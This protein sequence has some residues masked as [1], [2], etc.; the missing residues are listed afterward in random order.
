MAFYRIKEEIQLPLVIT[1]RDYNMDKELYTGIVTL[2]K[3][4]ISPIIDTTNSS[5]NIPSM[6]IFNDPKCKIISALGLCGVDAYFVLS[7]I[8]DGVYTIDEVFVCNHPHGLQGLINE[9]DGK[10]TIFNLNN[11]ARR[12]E[13]RYVPVGVANRLAISL[14]RTPRD[15]DVQHIIDRLTEPDG[16]YNN[17]DVYILTP[18]EVEP[19]F[20]RAVDIDY[21][22]IIVVDGGIGRVRVV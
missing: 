6:F 12:L 16:S 19:I 20:G 2:L 17:Q 3:K 1:D 21:K 13:R 11:L 14:G 22:I 5:L 4:G 18:H 7:Q 9:L 8:N 10:D 15:T